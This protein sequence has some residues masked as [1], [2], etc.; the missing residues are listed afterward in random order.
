MPATV[1]SR[2]VVKMSPLRV[3]VIYITLAAAWILL[4][5]RALGTLG[6]SADRMA[7]LQTLKGL[8][9]IS[10][11]GLVIYLLTR[12]AVRQSNASA[13]ALLESEQRF[14]RMAANI[15]GA[16]FRYILHPDGTDRV[17]YM[18][19]G[20]RGVWEIGEDEI[21]RNVR[22]LWEM[23]APEDIDAVRASV[24]DSAR[25]LRPWS[26]EYR[27]VT[28]S[29]VRKWIQ[30]YGQPTR[31]PDGETIWDSAIF[32]ITER[33]CAEEAARAAE[34]RLSHILE[35]TSEG[36]LLLDD[37]LRFLAANQSALDM[38]GRSR[39]DLVGRPAFE[40]FP[41][42]KHSA[43]HDAFTGA[44]RGD[45]ARTAE[46]RFEPLDKWFEAKIE[47]SG[48]GI[49]VF[50]RDVT[51][52][53][54]AEQR[55]QF[56]MRELDHRVKNNLAAVLAIAESSLREAESLPEFEESF[57]G[58]IRAM[59]SMHSLL[60][61]RRW[62]GVSLVGMIQA[63]LAPYAES[64]N[65]NA[66]AIEGEDITLPS[67]S[68]PAICMTVHELATNAAKHGAL[69]SPSGRVRI[70]WTIDPVTEDLR[71]VWAER[72]GP[73]VAAT[74]E[75]GFGLDLL[76]GVIPYELNGDIRLQFT[77]DG[78]QASIFVPG[79]AIRPPTR[80]ERAVREEVS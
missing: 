26:H 33:K 23:I 68:A 66:V 45:A 65:H 12:A 67:N 31:G 7:R 20:C 1:R 9:F 16:I 11:S 55:Q 53:R 2:S 73:P 51:E 61:A 13:T 24:E 41:F 72:G 52:R 48:E 22:V 38:V 62:E 34:R 25:A 5:D 27:I 19:P 59:A 15:P 71:L 47:R 60:A 44:I 17:V 63:I 28:P 75:P 18:S 4:S 10:A 39:D 50:F 3:G 14:R 43:W 36:F 30:G 80:A 8:T 42:L 54:R 58:R 77:P 49:A 74:I 6:L 79:E 37:Q 29:G 64:G 46:G 56:M 76:Q 35:R 57:I 78:L 69:S 21:L 32:D 70:T 40:A